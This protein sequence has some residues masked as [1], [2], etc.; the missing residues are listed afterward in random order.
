MEKIRLQIW[1]KLKKGE[2]ED[3]FEKVRKDL[4][5]IEKHGENSRQSAGENLIFNTFYFANF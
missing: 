1:E 3:K 4:E 2:I 5:E